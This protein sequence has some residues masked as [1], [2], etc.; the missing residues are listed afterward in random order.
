ME[1]R[2]GFKSRFGLIA[3]VGG[4]VVGLGNIWR[5][6]YLAGENGGAAFIL[7]YVLICFL[8]SVPIMITELSIGRAG[9]ADVVNSF[10]KVAP[11]TPWHY[12]GFFGVLTSVVV[13]S[14]YSVVAGWS[15][16]FVY[17]SVMNNFEGLNAVE[18][19]NNLDT[20]VNSGWRPVMW[21]IVFVLATATV[22]FLGIEKGIEKYNKFM[23]P[24][25]IFIL[26]GLIIASFSMSGFSEGVR[27]LFSPD[28][29]KIT[30]SVI[31]Q[32]LGQSFFSLSLGMGT[33]ITY[34]SYINK[35]ANIPKLAATISI[36]DMIV[37]VLAGIAIFPAVF[38]FGISP[39]SGPELVFITL[40][41]VFNQLPGGYFIS[42]IF[43]ILLFV[44][45]ITSSVS[46]IEVIVAYLKEEYKIKRKYGVLIT[47]L[48]VM[49]TGSLA[50]VSQ[51]DNS[52][53]KVFGE[54]LFDFFNNVSATYLFPTAAFFT[55]IFAGWFMKTSTLKD[56]I[57]NQGKRNKVAFPVVKFLVKFI[58]PIVI[59]LL[60]LN[61]VGV[62]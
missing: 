27:F 12:I 59:L 3:A 7:V 11:K 15:L 42:I 52:T 36:T 6:P 4:S 1:N 34:G 53:I 48:I 39:T 14:F 44:A 19:K 38:S 26:I 46:M 8:I 13:F 40:P 20:F 18:V 32:A 17:A 2:G 33:M 30:P 47:V 43:F 28:F 45:A 22:A 50:A 60:F 10:R 37:A 56:E 21:T 23:M 49:V 57:T 62:I 9:G 55:V 25:I 5:F 16:E 41:S 35:K 58:A 51:M 31:L 61:L 24:M 54:N 29:S